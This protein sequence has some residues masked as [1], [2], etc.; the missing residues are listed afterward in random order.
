MQKTI[1]YQLNESYHE[2]YN[3]AQ[4]E[5]YA[6]LKTMCSC[7]TRYLC[8]ACRVALLLKGEEL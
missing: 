1:K 6:K 2:G 7:D 8:I 4:N 3:D 5:T